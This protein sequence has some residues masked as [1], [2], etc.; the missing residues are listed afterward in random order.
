MP[1]LAEDRPPATPVSAEQKD[2][3]QRILRAAARHGADKGLERVQM[4]DVARDAG[5]AIATLYRYFPSKTHLFTALMQSQ[6][7]RLGDGPP[8]HR[9]GEAPEEGVSR[10]LVRAGRE[11]LKTPL[12]AH[13]MVQSNNSTL[14]T[15]PH[16]G[17]DSLFREQLIAASGLEEPTDYEIRLLLLLEQAWYGLVMA[18]LNQGEWTSP[19]QFA[20][21]TDLMC[22]LL[23]RGLA[24]AP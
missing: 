17:V 20:A 24:E 7:S 11:L 19:T 13:A 4:H 21:D 3:Y 16:S 23:L 22:R 8:V 12:L 1:R 2:R 10:L 18:A 15:A 6:V 5:V 14:A 9:P